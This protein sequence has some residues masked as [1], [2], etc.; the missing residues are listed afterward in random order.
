MVSG[1]RGARCGL[2]AKNLYELFATGRREIGERRSNRSSGK[3]AEFEPGFDDGRRRTR[4][5]L[6]NSIDRLDP[7]L[8]HLE[9]TVVFA[10]NRGSMDTGRDLGHE[11]GDP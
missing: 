4:P 7:I 2:L 8:H 5:A 3:P 6:A 9:Y 1:P 11:V 10:P